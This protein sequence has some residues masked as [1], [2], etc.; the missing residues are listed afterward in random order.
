MT[1]RRDVVNRTSGHDFR[2]AS[3]K[4]NLAELD[5]HREA[6]MKNMVNKS[7]SGNYSCSISATDF[8]TVSVHV[9]TVPLKYTTWGRF[10]HND[11]S[12][13]AAASTF[14]VTH[15]VMFCRFKNTGNNEN[16]NEFTS[17]YTVNQV[18]TKDEEAMLEDYILKSSRMNYGLTYLQIRKIA[19][20]YA[21]SVG[22]CPKKRL[23][24]Y[25][26]RHTRLSLRKPENSSQ[27]C[28]TSFN[29]ENVVSFQHNYEKMLQKC[30]FTADI[31]YNLHETT[32]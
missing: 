7:D 2:P 24:G 26:E 21:K 28:A 22:Q 13:R 32:A 18:F 12:I 3:E 25:A 29:K 6:W 14:G 1:S 10:E 27:S 4:N 19:F 9:L 30:K 16:R 17:K 31:I 23:K 11:M 20:E 8:A 15:T 5:E